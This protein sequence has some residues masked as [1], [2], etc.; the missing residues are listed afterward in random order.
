[1]HV[2]NYDYFVPGDGLLLSK[3]RKWDRNRRLM[4]PAFHMDILKNYVKIFADST[5]ILLVSGNNL[6][7]MVNLSHVMR[8]PI[9]WFPNR[10]N[11][12]VA[13]QAKKRARGLK[14]GFR[15]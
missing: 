6:F 12:K 9:I 10:F 1:M 4:T 7:W 13:V 15:K 8:K 11:I 5:K 2:Y 14:F 3:G